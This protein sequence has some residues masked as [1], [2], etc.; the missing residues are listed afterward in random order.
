MLNT[1]VMKVFYNSQG[2]PCKDKERTVPYPIVGQSFLGASNT[3]EIRF[4]YNQ[5]GDSNTSWVAVAKLPNGR[6]GSKVLTKRFDSE[7]IEPYAKLELS[8]FYTQFKGDL[9]ISLQGYQGGIDYTYDDE[10]DIYTINGTPTIQ[11]TGSVKLNIAYA[12]PFVGSDEEENVTLQSLLALIGTK[13]SYSSNDYITVIE[14]ITDYDLTDWEEGHFFFTEDDYSFY[15]KD[16]NETLGYKL[17]ASF[18]PDF[19]SYYTKDEIDTMLQNYYTKTEVNTMFSVESTAR[20]NAERALG[21][22]I[23]QVLEISDLS[24]PLTAEQL[25][26]ANKPNIRIKYGNDFYEKNGETESLIAFSC[27][28]VISEAAV[29]SNGGYTILKQKHLYITKSNGEIMSQ[30]TTTNFYNRTQLDT[31][32]ACYTELEAYN[33][34]DTGGLSNG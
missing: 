32:V 5:L 24:T 25:V 8:S 3:T 29:D 1:R 33:I 30:A 17:L 18:D 9:F 2:I 7:E 20:Q 15:Q 12:T 34:L 6:V 14:T 16:S 26:I 23:D 10:E 28:N 19:S 22:R 27:A 31:K 13:V 21:N 4:Y 11:A